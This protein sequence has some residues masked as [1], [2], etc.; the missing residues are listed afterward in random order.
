MRRHD[1]FLPE[2]KENYYD[3]PNYESSVASIKLPSHAYWS[4]VLFG[5]YSQLFIVSPE[6]SPNCSLAD[7]DS[8]R[9]SLPPGTWSL[10]CQEDT[11]AGALDDGKD[12][13]LKAV[14]TGSA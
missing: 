1:L 9:T 11:R 6:T 13:A 12:V 7:D 2:E 14:M 4:K 3:L 10:D 8:Q 5:R